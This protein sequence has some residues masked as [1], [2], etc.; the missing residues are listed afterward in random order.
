MIAAFPGAHL[1]KTRPEVVLSTPEYHKE[2]PDVILGLITSKRADILCSTDYEIQ[3]WQLAGLHAP[4][5]FRLYLVTLLQH[6]VRVIGGLTERD[7]EAVKLRVATQT[8][9]GSRVS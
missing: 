4:S 1:T 8:A 6:D 9:A 2:R 3:D 5:H 7:W